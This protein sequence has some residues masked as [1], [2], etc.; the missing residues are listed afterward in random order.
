MNRRKWVIAEY[1]YR[2]KSSL[3]AGSTTYFSKRKSI[4]APWRRLIASNGTG[5]K[6]GIHGYDEIDQ[7]V[8]RCHSSTRIHESR[9]GVRI[10][11]YIFILLYHCILNS[12]ATS[13]VQVEF[14]FFLQRSALI[15]KRILDLQQIVHD[16]MICSSKIFRLSFPTAPCFLLL[17]PSLRH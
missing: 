9:V 8:E 12:L 16:Y 14:L 6:W 10:Q 1:T 17:G 11:H 5:V 13:S 2:I 4:C 7:D 15:Y 3:G